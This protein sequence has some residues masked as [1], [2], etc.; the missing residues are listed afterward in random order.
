[1]HRPIAFGE[2]VTAPVPIAC[3]VWRPAIVL[4]EDAWQWPEDRLRIVLLHELA[5]IK[6]YDYLTLVLAQGLC[7]VYWFNPLAWVAARCL[8]AERERACDDVVLATGTKGSDY[9]GHLVEIARAMQTR[10]LPVP[11][12]LSIAHRSHLENRLIAILDPRIRRSST[13]HARLGALAIVLLMSIP[14]TA[15]QLT[16]IGPVSSR[17]TIASNSH[18]SSLPAISPIEVPRV[19]SIR[20]READRDAPGTRPALPESPDGA[21]RRARQSNEFQWSG[22]LEQ[23]ETLEVRGL[24]GSIRTITS[25][26]G[27]IRVD[28]RISNPARVRVEVVKRE[29][30]ITI[31]TVVSTPQGDQ[32]EC[33]PGRRAGSA[34]PDEGGVDFVV[35]VPAGVRFAGSM[36]HGDIEVDNV[37][38]DVNV[39]T[40]N[41]DIALKL[42]HGHGVEFQGNLISGTIESDFPVHDSTPP[43]PSGGRA[44]RPGGPRIVQATIGNGGP[45]LRVASINGNIRLWQR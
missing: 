7:A 42:S 13:R 6:R 19:I 11:A 17:A 44:G 18:R 26:N 27:G 3:G 15:V 23:G 30:G 16:A 40:I 8:C 22:N 39:A 35:R 28:A 25:T 32:S 1:M 43:L 38:S 24:S 31:C 4:P 10:W 14:I 2:S 29:A 9:A 41:G 12:G 5:H 45:A 34:Q 20:E 37:R 33:H 36:V 21:A